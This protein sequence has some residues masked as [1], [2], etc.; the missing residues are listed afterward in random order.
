MSRA[1]AYID[2]LHF[3]KA[4]NILICSATLGD[5]D[6]LKKY[7]DRVSARDFVV[8]ENKKRWKDLV[9]ESNIPVS[10]IRDA[11]VVAFS[12]KGCDSI[13]ENIIMA[14]EENLDM[15]KSGMRTVR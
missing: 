9:Y 3:S 11:L 10:K 4:E 2:A 14:R 12:A 7:I 5:L 1:R 8:Y 6:G 13:R 15:G